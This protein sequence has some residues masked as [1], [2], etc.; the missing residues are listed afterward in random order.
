[1]AFENL[2]DPGKLRSS[3]Q[4]IELLSPGTLRSS[5]RR[6]PSAPPAAGTIL[7]AGTV[8]QDYMD[9]EDA[10]IALQHRLTPRLVSARLVSPGH[11]RE[12]Q[13]VTWSPVRSASPAR[14]SSPARTVAP[15]IVQRQSQEGVPQTA[16]WRTPS[17][18][19]SLLQASQENLDVVEAPIALQRGPSRNSSPPRPVL[20]AG[21]LMVRKHAPLSVPVQ[22]SPVTSPV[23]S[24]TFA[25]SDMEAFLAKEN[26]P[27]AVQRLASTI[28]SAVMKELSPTW[29]ELHRLTSGID[30]SLLGMK[31]FAEAAERSLHVLQEFKEG[32]DKVERAVQELHRS[33]RLNAE[34][35]ADARRFSK[36]SLGLDVSHLVAEISK[37]KMEL[38][39]EIHRMNVDLEKH[40]HS[41]H[42][43]RDHL[44]MMTGMIR[45]GRAE[46][47]PM[48]SSAAMSMPPAMSLNSPFMNAAFAPAVPPANVN[49]ATL[50]AIGGTTAAT[51]GLGSQPQLSTG[52]MRLL[53][54]PQVTTVTTELVTP[55]DLRP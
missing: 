43:N 21:S 14:S 40:M 3:G 17:W 11:Q 38:M 54:T 2:L 51:S 15:P 9:M 49:A 6:M 23:K 27:D 53:P 25:A 16:R 7:P 44:D 48:D 12:A 47:P 10:K 30:R 41:I 13:R 31:S 20:N 36:S 35:D 39:Q 42:N 22:V 28:A 34:A 8:P 1:M 33:S 55:G 5:V 52:S 19:P 26:S 18:P 24:S 29:K 50:Y 32:Q 45:K 4:S 46:E 37:S